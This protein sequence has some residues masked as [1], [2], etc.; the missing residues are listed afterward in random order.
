MSATEVVPPLPD[1]MTLLTASKAVLLELASTHGLSTVG[2][3]NDL[4]ARLLDH[5]TSVEA[6]RVA[7]QHVSPPVSRHNTPQPTRQET[8]SEVLSIFTF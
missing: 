4:L 1:M 8:A 2:S 5:V 3:K 7:S 6:H